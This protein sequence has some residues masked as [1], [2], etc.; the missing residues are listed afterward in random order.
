M[1]VWTRN[2]PKSLPA[3]H[4]GWLQDEPQRPK[5]DP[6]L[7]VVAKRQPPPNRTYNNHIHAIYKNYAFGLEPLKGG[8]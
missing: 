1:K 7:F 8:N 6:E 2:G 4:E 5:S 3:V